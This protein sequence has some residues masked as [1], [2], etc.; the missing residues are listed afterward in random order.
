MSP[1]SKR[2][3]IFRLIFTKKHQKGGIDLPII[4][5]GLKNPYFSSLSD[6]FRSQKIRLLDVQKKGL[7]RTASEKIR[8]QKKRLS[9]R[10]F[11]AISKTVSSTFSAPF[12]L[13]FGFRGFFFLCQHT[14]KP[15]NRLLQS[16][17]QHKVFKFSL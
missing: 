16:T 8:L 2:F 6:S 13:R 1:F 15:F 7:L 11:S 14:A 12:P 9:I 17:F 3:F 10:L 4:E 5:I